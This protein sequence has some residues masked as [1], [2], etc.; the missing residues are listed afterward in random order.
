[1]RSVDSSSKNYNKKLRS[2][3]RFSF[4]ESIENEQNKSDSKAIKHKEGSTRK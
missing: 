3:Q 4:C 2:K 1:M